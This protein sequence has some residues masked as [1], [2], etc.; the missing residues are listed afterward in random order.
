MIGV[1]D[2]LRGEVPKA[3]VTCCKGR[4]LAAEDLRA[5]L[6]DRLS[7]IEMPRE[8]EFRHELPRSISGKV[9]K[10]SLEQRRCISS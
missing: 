5:F 9:L 10:T 8:I 6:A 1:P 4:A 2:H 7:P 3:Y